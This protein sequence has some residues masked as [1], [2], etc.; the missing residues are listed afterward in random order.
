MKIND[1]IIDNVQLCAGENIK[2]TA[3]PETQ[4]VI[5]EA[6]TLNNTRLRNGGFVVSGQ[7]II[8]DA[9][10]NIVI[11]TAHPNRLIIGVN[12]DKEIARIIELEKRVENF[13][14]AIALLIGD[15]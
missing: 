8:I 12:I 10:R 14:K 13:E 3:D 4:R 15:K 2:I 9:G 7:E 1:T 5:I 6:P 11:T